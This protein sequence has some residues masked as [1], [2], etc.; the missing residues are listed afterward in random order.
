MIPLQSITWDVSPIFF[1]AGPLQLRWY[2]LFFALAFILGF[3]IVEWMYRRE[4]KPVEDL[5]AGLIYMLVGT[6]VGARLGHVFF[7]QAEY[8]L[9][10]PAQIPMIW[11]GGLASHGAVI[12]ILVALWLY[13]RSRDDQPYLWLLDRVAVPVAL[14]GFFIR[15]GNFFNSEILGEPTDLP[16]AVIFERIDMVPRHPTQLY[17]ALA[18]L[19]I[20][21]V[22]FWLYRRYARRA[23]HGLLTGAFLTLVF[24][25]RFLL[26]FTKAPQAAF[27]A[28]L[29]LSMGQMLSIIPVVVGMGLFLR[30][31]RGLSPRKKAVKAP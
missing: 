28:G 8:Y 12:G 11:H 24:S 20:F 17:E 14:A 29:P 4:G 31:W 7:Y 10:N 30:A 3:Y 18:Y 6:L 23:P 26:E 19:T 13:A 21:G 1:E 9:A 25:A 2:G 16:W 15:M 22:L 5:N 27:E